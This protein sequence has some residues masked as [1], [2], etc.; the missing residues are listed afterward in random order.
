MYEHY[1]TKMVVFGGNQ[2]Q[3]IEYKGTSPCCD[4]GGRR[5]LVFTELS[6]G[7]AGM[8]V[9]E[10]VEF[11]SQIKTAGLKNVIETYFFSYI[12]LSPRLE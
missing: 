7:M 3:P 10:W 11:D 2:S 1:Q 9:L 6:A 12:S 5:M 4:V 8:Q